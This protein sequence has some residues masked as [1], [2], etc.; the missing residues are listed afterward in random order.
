MSKEPRP[1]N[2]SDTRSLEDS[3]PIIRDYPPALLWAR[4]GEEEDEILQEYAS[5]LYPR[6]F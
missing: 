6:F 4:I 3:I 1:A 2:N 5:L